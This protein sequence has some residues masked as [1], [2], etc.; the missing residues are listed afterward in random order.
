MANQTTILRK[1]TEYHA[2]LSLFHR[3]YVGLRNDA[4]KQESC[5]GKERTLKAI[6]YTFVKQHN[7]VFNRTM[8]PHHSTIS[9]TYEIDNPVIVIKVKRI[10][11]T[12]YSFMAILLYT[13]DL[14]PDMR[15]PAMWYVRPAKPQIS[16]RIR[17]VRSELLLVA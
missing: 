16:L 6:S 1:V 5:L 12:V 8:S 2:L 13:I 4:P 11:K 3:R 15:F 9:H 7:I 10:A 17:A 14:S